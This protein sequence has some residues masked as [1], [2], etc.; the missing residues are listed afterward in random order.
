LTETTIRDTG[1]ALISLT[2]ATHKN[3]LAG[4]TGVPPV[5]QQDAPHSNCTTTPWP[6]FLIIR[7]RW[8]YYSGQTCSVGRWWSL[9]ENSLKPC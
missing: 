9:M 8:P 5:N 1:A 6:K 3:F 2:A 4:G 7:K